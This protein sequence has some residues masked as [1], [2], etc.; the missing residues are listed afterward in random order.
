M[1]WRQIE[2]EIERLSENALH[3][4]WFAPIVCC[5]LARNERFM[6]QSGFSAR[7][8][9]CFR[10]K[11]IMC[12]CGEC[13]FCVVRFTIWRS[14]LHLHCMQSRETESPFSKRCQNKNYSFILACRLSQP[15]VDWDCLRRFLY[16]GHSPARSIHESTAVFLHYSRLA[17]IGYIHGLPP[18][19]SSLHSHCLLRLFGTTDSSGRS[20]HIH[21]KRTLTLWSEYSLRGVEY[22]QAIFKQKKIERKRELN[23][24]KMYFTHTIQYNTH[25]R[26][27]QSVF[28]SIVDECIGRVRVVSFTIMWFYAR[29]LIQSPQC[30]IEMEN[31][32]RQK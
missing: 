12:G 23:N 32:V 3:V 7:K 8:E 21:P 2:E 20:P 28:E 24:R 14:H 5:R 6:I 15:N 13:I 10:D 17:F 26:I 29:V 22:I 18:S 25:Q 11:P 31:G 4:I 30:E 1:R 16:R 19:F 9:R 27:P